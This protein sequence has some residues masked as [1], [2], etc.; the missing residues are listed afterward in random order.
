MVTLAQILHEPLVQAPTCQVTFSLDVLVQILEGDSLIGLAFLDETTKTDAL[1]R[2]G[3]PGTSP[4]P[5]ICYL[6][7]V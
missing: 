3:Q 4:F 7:S 1:P 5:L 2:V 6:V